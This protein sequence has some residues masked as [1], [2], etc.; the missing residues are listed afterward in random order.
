MRIGLGDGD[1]G[2]DSVPALSVSWDVV[3]RELCA[4]RKILRTMS[5]VLVR[6]ADS[7]DSLG[8][9]V[10]ESLTLGDDLR[11]RGDQLCSQGDRL[12]GAAGR[13]EEELKRGRGGA[14]AG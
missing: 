3:Y 6:I 10:D 14:E 7:T 4:M 1:A 8:G 9:K 5:G 11:T 2:Q 13:L 12:E